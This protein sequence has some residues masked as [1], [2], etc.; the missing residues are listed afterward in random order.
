M[1]SLRG[2]IDPKM[3]PED[4]AQP[5]AEEIAVIERWIDA[6]AK[7]PNGSPDPTIAV[8]KGMDALEPKMRDC[9]TSDGGKRVW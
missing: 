5:T 8:F 2:E 4:E 9:C 3:P 7:G 1:R 6:G